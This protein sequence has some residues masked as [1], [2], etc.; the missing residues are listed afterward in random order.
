MAISSLK[1]IG[2]TA[3][4]GVLLAG[5]ANAAVTVNV[6]EAIDVQVV[7]LDK[8]DLSGSLFDTERH[9][10]LPDGVNQIAFRYSQ[11]FINREN[12]ERVYGPFTIMK[13]NATDTELTFRVPEYRTKDDAEREVNQYQWGLVDESG[14]DIAVVNDSLSVTG[15]VFGENLINEVERYNKKGGKAAVAMSYVTVNNVPGTMQASNAPV[16]QSKLVDKEVAAQN[17]VLGGLQSLYLQASPEERKAFRRW[18][19][20]QD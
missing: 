8:P 14:N 19:I 3:L 13:F 20:D 5:S 12:A 17:S 1:N 6:P 9:L 4:A 10:E 16:V 7:N 15:F 18:M 11:N 2:Y